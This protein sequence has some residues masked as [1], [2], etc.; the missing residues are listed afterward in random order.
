MNS[1]CNQC[2]FIYGNEFYSNELVHD[3]KFKFKNTGIYFDFPF[4]QLQQLSIQLQSNS[5][6]EQYDVDFNYDKHNY[7]NDKMEYNFASINIRGK[8][9]QK[10]D[11][12]SKLAMLVQHYNINILGMQEIQKSFDSNRIKIF[13]GAFKVMD[14]V[15]VGDGTKGESGI[16]F[17]C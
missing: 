11:V 7:N 15:N 17:S 5:N 6:L 1:V 9:S 13:N 12:N 2:N 4:A 3:F 16:D 14:Y 10:F 8:Y